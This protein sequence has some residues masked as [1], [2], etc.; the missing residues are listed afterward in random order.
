MV[1]LCKIN[2]LTGYLSSYDFTD[3]RVGVI[4]SGSSS[5]QIVPALQKVK[6]VHIDAFVR[7]KTWIS[8]P[9]GQDLWDEI[10]LQGSQCT[11][12]YF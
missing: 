7:N 12:G 5:I 4:G 11:F 9:F 3:K 10:G 8:P 2:R 6:G 1:W